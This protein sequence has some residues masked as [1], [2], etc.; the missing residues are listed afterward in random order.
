MAMSLR[1][2]VMLGSYIIYEGAQ[3]DEAYSAWHL[4]A[5]K[6][7]EPFTEDSGL[8]WLSFLS[9]APRIPVR[10]LAR[11]RDTECLWRLPGSTMLRELGATARM[12]LRRQLGTLPTL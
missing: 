6:R 1:T 3:N 12:T 7:L 9:L 2:D 4:D 10:K 5:M 11:L 8:A